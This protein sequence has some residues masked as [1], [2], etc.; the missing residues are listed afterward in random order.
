MKR[1]MVQ[2]RYDRAQ[3]RNDFLVGVADPNHDHKGSQRRLHLS[4][5]HM[6][7]ASVSAECVEETWSGHRFYIKSLT[8]HSFDQGYK[9][10]SI[11]YLKLQERRRSH[12]GR[13]D[14]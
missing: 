7:R 1:T 2:E 11:E 3:R 5:N 14:L 4:G 12:M 6:C 10:K 8:L 9:W 13:L